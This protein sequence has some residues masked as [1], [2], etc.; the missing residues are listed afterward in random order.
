MKFILL[1]S[2]LLPFGLVSQSKEKLFLE[3]KLAEKNDEYVLMDSLLLEYIQI[4]TTNAEAYYLLSHYKEIRNI[5]YLNRALAIDSTYLDALFDRADYYLFYADN[6]AL[7]A[8]DFQTTYNITGDYYD[9]GNLAGAK[10]CAD[11][12]SGAYSD[13][14]KIIEYCESLPTELLDE[15]LYAD[16]HERL[17]NVKY[18]TCDYEGAVADF[19]KVEE[20]NLRSISIWEKLKLAKCY[21]NLNQH[22]ECCKVID[23]CLDELDLE[24][25]YQKE[26][27]YE[28]LYLQKKYCK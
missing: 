9:L 12:Y 15:Q 2:I 7:A 28:L 19:L 1:L 21:I 27:S 16:G 22:D 25:V 14:M 10:L 20:F 18:A 4:D 26:F 6:C 17:A 5:D 8:K 3:I 13:C 11:D 23:D 24:I